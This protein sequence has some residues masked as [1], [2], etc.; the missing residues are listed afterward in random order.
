MIPIYEQGGGRGIGHSMRSFIDR[1]EEICRVHAEQGRA[2]AFAFIFYDFTNGPFRRV[3]KDQGVFAKLDRLSGDQLSIFYLHAATHS[4]VQ[5]FNATFA[6]KLGVEARPPCV[7]FFR[8]SKKGVT[9]VAVAGLD[10]SDLIHCFNELYGTVEEYL[11]GAAAQGKYLRWAKSS[12]K[13]VAT[14]GI[15]EAV[16]KGLGF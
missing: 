11:A 1:F 3:L 10:S 4:G 13:W 16:K 12:A 7:A 6:E 2:K 15:K 5:Q 9:D 8:L 14:E